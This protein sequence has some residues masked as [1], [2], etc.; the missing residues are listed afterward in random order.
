MKRYGGPRVIVTDRLGSYG[1][2][3]KVIGVEDRQLCGRW[4]QQSSRKLTPT[5]PPTRTSDGQVQG[6]Q[7]RAE[8]CCRPRLH[9]QSF[10]PGTSFLQSRELQTQSLRRLGR[11]ASTCS[12]SVL[13]GWLYWSDQ[14]SLTMPSGLLP[15][16]FAPTTGS[17]PGAVDAPFSTRGLAPT[18]NRRSS[19]AARS[20]RQAQHS[21][22]IKR[23]IP[24][25]HEHR[26]PLSTDPQ[27][28]P[29]PTGPGERDF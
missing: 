21:G 6:R 18:E 8:V 7:D 27:R 14:V 5:V 24:P 13:D 15:C 23:N 10:Q 29:K 4:A 25:I 2:A 3:M 1:A 12:L 22:P 16:T 17:Y 28:D 26:L 19:P 20:W 11:V 9:P